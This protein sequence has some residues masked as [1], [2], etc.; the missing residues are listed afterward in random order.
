VGTPGWCRLLIILGKG[1]IAGD[2]PMP[3][4]GVS[5]VCEDSRLPQTDLI[6]GRRFR[7]QELEISLP[8][9]VVSIRTRTLTSQAPSSRKMVWCL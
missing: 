7:V 4:N 5:V 3:R 2:R 6:V 9:L 8:D 1:R